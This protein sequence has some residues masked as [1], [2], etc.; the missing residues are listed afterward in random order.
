[1][2]LA[3]FFLL[4][5][6]ARAG[7][8]SPVVVE[9]RGANVGPSEPIIVRFIGDDTSVVE[10]EVAD[11]GRSPDF[12][13][14]DGIW[15]GRGEIAG[16]GFQLRLVAG[17]RSMPATR[18]EWV[19]EGDRHLSLVVRGNELDAYPTIETAA[20]LA[21]AAE[22]HR[23]RWGAPFFWVVA[24]LVAAIAAA[25]RWGL[26]GRVLGV[27]RL[28]E[29]PILDGRRVPRA[30]VGVADVEA[31][32]SRLVGALAVARTVVVVGRFPIPAVAPGRVLAL[33]GEEPERLI[34]AVAARAGQP[35]AVVVVVPGSQTEDWL[36][37]IPELPAEVPVFVL[38]PAGEARPELGE[39]NGEL[40]WLD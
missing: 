29:V 9:L 12:V 11:N 17:S 31:S 30:A 36:E 16:A 22:Q 40:A 6:A 37:V 1:M 27:N 28:P 15:A 3:A 32:A 13:A 38:V 4:L 26:R 14:E 7:A 21:V 24:A 10:V 39:L 35:L 5:S 18:V 23:E 34:A 33:K 25:E 20:T 2:S 19:Q 8:S